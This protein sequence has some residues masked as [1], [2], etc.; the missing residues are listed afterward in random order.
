MRL[1]GDFGGRA[2]KL[3]FCSAE[4]TNVVTVLMADAVEVALSKGGGCVA[5][6]VGT[7]FE[8][9]LGREFNLPIGAVFCLSSPGLLV[10]CPPARTLNG[11]IP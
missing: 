1:L 5:G 4:P 7:A 3:S 2:G 9:R 11:S 10:G 6:L 8:K